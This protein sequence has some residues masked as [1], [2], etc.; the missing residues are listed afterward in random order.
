M[1][2]LVMAK[3]VLRGQVVE[4]DFNKQLDRSGFG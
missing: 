3:A 2:N 1:G 4:N